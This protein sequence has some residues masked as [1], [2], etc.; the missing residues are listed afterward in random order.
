MKTILIGFTCL[1]F[2]MALIVVGASRLVVM[3]RKVYSKVMFGK[4]SKTW[5][6]TTTHHSSS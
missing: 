1:M 6:Y 3:I 5:L 2:M 4:P